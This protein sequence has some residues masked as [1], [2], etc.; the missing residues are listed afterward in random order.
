MLGSIIFHLRNV[1][2]CLFLTDFQFQSAIES[3]QYLV[4]GDV[5]N[6]LVAN[7]FLYAIFDKLL[8]I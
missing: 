8:K 3:Y 5:I 6:F 1:S 2:L 7:S 4:F